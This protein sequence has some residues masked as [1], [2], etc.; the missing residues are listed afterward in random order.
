VSQPRPSRPHEPR[1]PRRLQLPAA[2]LALTALLGAAA[3]DSTDPQPTA[4]LPMLTPSPQPQAAPAP[5]AASEPVTPQAA[6]HAV[7][8]NPPAVPALPPTAT[9]LTLAA[10]A[11]GGLTPQYVASLAQLPEPAGTAQDIA[12]RFLSALRERQWADAAAQMSLYSRDR[13][14]YRDPAQVATIL[15]DVRQ[16]A[17]GDAFG[18]CT[19]TRQIN[20]S[21]VAVTCGRQ[22]VVVHVESRFVPG[23]QIDSAHP[24]GDVVAE[25]HLHAYTDI[26]L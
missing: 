4:S 9:D 23:V 11:P 12:L 22:L 20:P 18:A 17:G 15:N 14:S 24:D 8:G 3:C 19:G 21:A 6:P 26:E 10:P 13:L 16:H 7:A 1:S 5:P 25:S 2:A